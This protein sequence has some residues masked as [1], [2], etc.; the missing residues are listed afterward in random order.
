MTRVIKLG[1][2]N[3][4]PT[5]IS[6]EEAFGEFSE[7]RGKGRA[8]RAAR[9]ADRIEKRKTKKINRIEARDEVKNARQEARMGRRERRKSTRQS[10]RSEQ[11]AARQDR[12]NFRA[13]NRLSRKA[14]RGQNSEENAPLEQGLDQGVDQ[15]MGQTQNQGYAPQEQGGGYDSGYAD[16]GSY[17]SGNS[18]QGSYD[19][20]SSDQGGYDATYTDA[21]SPYDYGN[22]ETGGLYEQGDSSE[23]YGNDY[24]NDYASDYSTDNDIPEGGDFNFD[25]IMGA[26]D[27]FNELSDTKIRVNPDIQSIADKLEWNKELVSRLEDKRNQSNANP[28]EISKVILMRTERIGDLSKQLD[29]YYNCCGNYSSMD[30]NDEKGKH[31][32]KKE[33]RCARMRAKSK[34]TK[35]Q[36]DLNPEITT[37]KIVVP[38]KEPNSNATGLNGLDLMNDYDAPNVREIQLGADGSKSNSGIKLSSVLLGVGI[39]IAVVWAV[40]KYNLIK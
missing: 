14:A 37:N 18:D 7:L 13:E 1:P 26:E 25:G 21:E 16:Q 5:N 9:K 29:D 36:K 28:Q 22:D 31:S 32:R 35:V 23:D 17:D 11:Q 20:G 10:I 30:A 38:A 3:S 39:G 6:F 19:S 2:V 8:R 27:R 24:G 34:L 15:E 33:I 12:R 4:S 40:K